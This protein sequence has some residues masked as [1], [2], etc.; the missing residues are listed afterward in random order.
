M[1]SKISKKT[2]KKWQLCDI[3]VISNRFKIR[4]EQPDMYLCIIENVG[5]FFLNEKSFKI[6]HCIDAVKTVKQIWD[7]LTRKYPHLKISKKE[8]LEVVNAYC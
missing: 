6:L 8:V 3:P 5:V 7:D 4:K 1:E 2:Q